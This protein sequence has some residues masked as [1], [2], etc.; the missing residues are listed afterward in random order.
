MISNV[1]EAPASESA[2]TRGE[3][4]VVLGLVVLL[5]GVAALLISR[6]R[7]KASAVV[8]KDNLRQLGAAMAIYTKEND[9]RLP[10]AFLMLS[11]PSQI[12]WDTLLRP[13][14]R[15]TTPDIAGT[16]GSSASRLLL[17]PADTIPSAEWAQKYKLLRRTYSM[18]RHNM[19]PQNWPP[20]STNATG[21]GVN[22]SFGPRGTNPPS[23][24]IYNSDGPQ[25][26]VRMAMILQPSETLFLAEHA[27]TNNIVANAAGAWIDRA[28]AHTDPAML[29]A[30]FYHKERFN[31]LQVDGRV[32]LLSPSQTVG[33]NGV[34]GDDPKRH[35][36]MWTIKAHD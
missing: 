31:Y 7:V 28:S 17:C 8:C 4:L 18:T 6:P 19:N 36:G 15:A 10:Y 1:G 12:S 9:T 30:N 26:A 11:N 25:A 27:W 34:A 35:L 22:W 13:A 29:P 24:K 3:L 14:L 16:N 2:F 32:E 20:S 23:P 5:A 21:L 33:P